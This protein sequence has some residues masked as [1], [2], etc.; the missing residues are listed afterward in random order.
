MKIVLINFDQNHMTYL[1][2]A[3]QTTMNSVRN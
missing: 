2:L 3:D 1:E